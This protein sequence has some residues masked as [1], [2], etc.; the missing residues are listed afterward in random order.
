MFF[1]GSVHLTSCSGANL[2]THVITQF[3]PL[4]VD[5]TYTNTAY[6]G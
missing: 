3:S 2:S 6:G 1:T 4:S 5:L